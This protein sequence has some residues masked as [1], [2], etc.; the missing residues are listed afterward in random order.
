MPQGRILEG[1]RPV[2]LAETSSVGGAGRIVTKVH[3]FRSEFP[4]LSHGAGGYEW[5]AHVRKR[6]TWPLLTRTLWVV[7]HGTP[8]FKSLGV[9]FECFGAPKFLRCY[10]CS[11]RGFEWIFF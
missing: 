4:D 10:L 1:C 6:G 2:F 8:I 3:G 5:M 11:T 7:F 9:G